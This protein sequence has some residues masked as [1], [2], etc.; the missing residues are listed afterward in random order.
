M[1]SYC[2]K[3]ALAN[4]DQHLKDFDELIETSNAEI[5]DSDCIIVAD[6]SLFQRFMTRDEQIRTIIEDTSKINESRVC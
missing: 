1:V 3:T 2:L 6:D 4:T 5:E